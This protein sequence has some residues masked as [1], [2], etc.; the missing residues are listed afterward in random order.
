MDEKLLESIG[1][2]E[3]ETR[4]YF[5][6]A[7]LGQT[8]TGA[9]AKEARVSSSKVYKILDRL[10]KKS[11]VGHIVK[12]EVK[13]FS[14][15]D[16]KM[17]L[18]YI[19]EKEKDLESKKKQVEDFLPTLNQAIEKSKV[20][21]EATLFEGVKAIKNFYLNILEELKSGEEYFVIGANYGKSYENLKD[22]FENYHM[23]RA[24]RKI[25]VNMLA[26]AQ[27]KG[28]LVPS[29]QKFSE[30]KF[31]PAY[32]ISN[33]TILFYKSKSFIFF[34]AEEPVGFL[35][36]NQEITNGFKTYFDAFW[37]IAKE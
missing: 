35:I 12:G 1:L 6:L 13:Y 21:S 37:K 16:P 3:G 2:T 5:A 24:K 27:T 33:M 4:V 17:I 15:A 22:F 14:L 9:L 34:F 36:E 30:V 28:I 29:T 7:K 11:L 18:K 10:E 26:N 19:E 20:K 31:L 25:K 8:R 32:L 23:Q